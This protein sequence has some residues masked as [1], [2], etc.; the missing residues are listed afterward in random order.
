MT[1]QPDS[2]ALRGRGPLR[3]VNLRDFGIVFGLLAIVVYLSLST[4]TFLTSGNLI[5][6]L[7]QATVVGLLATGATLCIISGVFDLSATATLAASAIVGVWA[8]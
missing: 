5:N 8:S 6:L 2:T 7:D 3:R 1:T 4:T